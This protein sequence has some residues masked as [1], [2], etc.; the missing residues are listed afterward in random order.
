MKIGI[1][2][3]YF[4]PYIGYWQLINCVDKYVI[5][6]DVNYIKNGWINRNRILI[7]KNPAYIKLP[8]VG[9][10]QNKLINE[11]EVSDDIQLFE[12]DLKT[13]YCSYK[14]APYFKDVY[15]LIEDIMLYKESNLAKY[16]ENSIRKICK[17]LD[18]ETEIIISSEL[19][20]NC[21]LKCQ[22][23]VIDICKILNGDEYINAIGGQ[24]LYSKEDFMSN[25]IK[26]EFLNTDEIYY[27]QFSDGMIEH[28]LSIIDVMMFN[29][30]EDVKKMLGE[31]TLI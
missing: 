18:I 5:A 11:I 6:D 30:K 12:K 24:K 21:N 31:Y 28:N 13:I 2:Q 25:G 16:L 3:P 14:K 1:M 9:A 29:S 10:S 19:N 20:K 22:D 8:L 26:L 15:P 17:Y 23:K 4:F 27:N 7:Q